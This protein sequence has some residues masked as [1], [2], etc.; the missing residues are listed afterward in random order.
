L[1][2][3]S[4]PWQVMANPQMKN[5]TNMLI[6]NLAV[7]D[8]LFVLVC[9]PFT[10]SDYVLMYWPFGL[11]W[12]RTVQYIIYVTAYVSIYT[13]VLMAGDRYLA[14]VF[15]V[16]SIVYR[17]VANA[18]IAIGLTWLA[19]LICVSPVWVAHNLIATNK[20]E[21]NSV[22]KVILTIYSPQIPTATTTE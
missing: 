12:C 13:L 20:R 17:T 3:A 1:L 15:P 18:R 22:W 2:I 9:I 11:F 19:T 5:T 7:A 4:F 14:V 6:L 8:L 16:N 10:A 21:G